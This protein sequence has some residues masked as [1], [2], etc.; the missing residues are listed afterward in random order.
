MSCCGDD[1]FYWDLLGVAVHSRLRMDVR[2]GLL[3]IG[4]VGYD[5]W[6]TAELGF[7]V[8]G[9]TCAVFVAVI[10]LMYFTF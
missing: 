2:L 3:G 4:F 10:T 7:S 5:Y 8:V 9:A 6:G 1:W